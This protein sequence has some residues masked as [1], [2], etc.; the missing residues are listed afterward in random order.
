[1]MR[2][3]GNGFSV[4]FGLKFK[5]LGLWRVGF[6]YIFLASHFVYILLQRP[7]ATLN[8]SPYGDETGHNGTLSLALSHHYSIYSTL[9][10]LEFL[11]SITPTYHWEPCQ[12][13]ARLRQRKFI[14]QDAVKYHFKMEFMDIKC[15]FF[16]L[17]SLAQP[18]F[19][20]S[21]FFRLSK[22][23]QCAPRVLSVSRIDTTPVT[24]HYTW[25][26]CLF[27]CL[28]SCF[29]FLSHSSSSTC[30]FSFLQPGTPIIHIKLITSIVFSL[31][32]AA[33]SH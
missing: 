12:V 26:Y 18:G 14:T 1:M 25:Q 23:Y 7:S 24:W 16:S 29:F 9:L 31:D 19:Y 28:L 22:S 15:Y 11:I 32:L 30:F 8:I 5:F 13:Y 21:A 20:S 3:N 17:L 4:G 27:S 2:L 6:W 10:S 33:R